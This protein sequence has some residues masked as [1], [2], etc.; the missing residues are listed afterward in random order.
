MAKKEEAKSNGITVFKK[1]QFIS[2]SGQDEQMKEAMEALGEVGLSLTP[3]DIPR[4]KV[5]S[6]GRTEWEIPRGGD[7]YERKKE[8]SG[9]LLHVQR[10]AV[11]WPGENPVAG[12][13]PVLRSWDLEEAEI[14]GP[15]PDEMKAEVDKYRI[16]GRDNWVDIRE[17]NGFGPNQW[18]TGKGGHGKLMKES[19]MVFILP[20]DEQFP[21]LINVGV[22]SLGVFDKFLKQEI[23]MRLKVPYFT[24]VVSLGL[25]KATSAGGV[26]YSKIV[27]KFAGLLDPATVKEINKT[28]REGLKSLA[29]SMSPAEVEPVA[30]GANDE[31][32]V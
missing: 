22:G 28:Y 4:V 2:L 14:V 10:C 19:R 24:T 1:D 26:T 9:A 30:A 15:V 6:E 31:D 18:G 21:F 16:A 11:L 27:P 12:T 7:E 29:K 5:P 17:E 32:F 8:L 13:P 3:Q 25:E 23:T 20:P